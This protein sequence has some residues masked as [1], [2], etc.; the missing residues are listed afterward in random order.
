MHKRI[1]LKGVLTFTLKHLQHVSVYTP[2]SESALFE[3]AAVTVIK[4]VNENTLDRKI[5]V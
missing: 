1:A 3:L 2:S 4:T 5:V